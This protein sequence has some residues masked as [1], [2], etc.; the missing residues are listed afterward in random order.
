MPFYIKNTGETGYIDRFGNE[1]Y[2]YT[3]TSV[4]VRIQ[5]GDYTPESFLASGQDRIE[6]SMPVAY[7]SL[8]RSGKFIDAKTQPGYGNAFLSGGEVPAPKL[9]GPGTG[10][11]ETEKQAG[12]FGDQAG[13]SN[14]LR[15]PDVGR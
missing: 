3:G 10:Q 13:G 8:S 1:W 14:R 6:N 4:D 9:T 2:G 15:R 5:S 11:G 12:I 7:E